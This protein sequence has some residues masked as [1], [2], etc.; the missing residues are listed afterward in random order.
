VVRAARTVLVLLGTI[1]LLLGTVAGV[2]NREVLDG[3]RFTSHVEAVRSDPAVARQLGTLLTDRLL[4][5]QPD[6]TAVRPLLLTTATSVVASPALAPAVRTGVS[7]LYRSLITGSGQDLVV[8]RLADAAAVVVGAL[9]IAAPQVQSTIPPDL[10]VRLSTFGGQE[11]RDARVVGWAHL[12]RR[13]AWVCPL[14]GVLLLAT[15]GA[16]VGRSRRRGRWPGRVLDACS[17]VGRGAV[18]A[19]GCLAVLLALVGFRVGRADPATLAGSL[20][21]AV[22]GQLSGPFWSA[23]GLTAAVGLLL[24]LFARRAV[25]VTVADLAPRTLAAEA[26]RVLQ[27]PGPAYRPRAVRAAF[28]LLLGS[29]RPGSCWSPVPSRCWCRS[30]SRS[31]ASAS[32]VGPVV[33][34]GPRHPAQ[35]AWPPPSG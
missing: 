6:L 35:G 30:S 8:L 2:V 25:D 17:E 3:P 12:A 22:W 18:T 19:A 26:W 14:L 24:L 33:P 4:E 16:T 5:A 1:L 15:S 32:P 34:T 13:M 29:G 23:A 7:P 31:P 10:D 21:H 28:F 9:A 27:D 20:Q 11:D